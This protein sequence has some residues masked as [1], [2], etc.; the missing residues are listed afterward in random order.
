[1]WDE[2]ANAN[3]IHRWIEGFEATKI[4]PGSPVCFASIQ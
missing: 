3:L 2:Q 1:M 4:L